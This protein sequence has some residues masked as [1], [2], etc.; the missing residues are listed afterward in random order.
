MRRHQIP[1]PQ[2]DDEDCYVIEDFNIGEK[3]TFYGR[4]FMIVDCDKFT[5][6]FLEKLG[7]QVPEALPMPLDP[8]TLEREVQLV[9]NS[10]FK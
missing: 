1:K 7:K 4:T 3:V 2:P 6:E 10:G 5:R 8:Y 9:N